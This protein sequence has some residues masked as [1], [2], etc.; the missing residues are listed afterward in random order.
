MGLRAQNRHLCP[1]LRIPGGLRAPPVSGCVL[2]FICCFSLSISSFIL[3]IWVSGNRKR[4]SRYQKR[5]CSRPAHQVRLRPAPFTALLLPRPATTRPDP[6]LLTLPQ[7]TLHTSQGVVCRTISENH[8][9]FRIK[10][11]NKINIK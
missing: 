5:L 3:A 8:S 1:G 4:R 9:S 2:A 6:A 7:P 10:K 11:Q